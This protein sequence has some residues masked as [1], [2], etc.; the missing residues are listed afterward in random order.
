MENGDYP[1][2]LEGLDPQR[3]RAAVRLRE[4]DGAVARVRDPRHQ[5]AARRLQRDGLART[6]GASV[7][8]RAR[9]GEFIH[10]RWRREA[11]TYGAQMGVDGV[12]VRFRTGGGCLILR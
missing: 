10:V 6:C 12:T 5:P 3:R 9:P 2:N 7:P 11:S 1:N 8:V 4:Q